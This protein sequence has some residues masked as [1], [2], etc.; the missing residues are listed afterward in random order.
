MRLRTISGAVKNN[1]WCGYAI[2]SPMIKLRKVDISLNT[3]NNLI[4]QTQPYQK[5]LQNL[6][7]S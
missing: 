6:I 5:H 3:P 2:L 7:T 1:K 4:V